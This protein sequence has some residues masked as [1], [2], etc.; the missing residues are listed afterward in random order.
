MPAVGAG[1]ERRDRPPQRRLGQLGGDVWIA[2]NEGKI[3]R[4]SGDGSWSTFHQEASVSFLA[5]GGTGPNDV[6]VDG[7]IF[8]YR[9]DGSVWTRG[10]IGIAQF[11]IAAVEG[12]GAFVGGFSSIYRRESG[13]TWASKINFPQGVSPHVWGMAL[14]PG[15]VF[16]VG[17]NAPTGVGIILQSSDRGDTWFTAAQGTFPT[18]LAVWG[19]SVDDLYACGYSGT[20]LRRK[21]AGWQSETSG[22]TLKLTSGTRVSAGVYVVGEQGTVLFSTGDGRWTPERSGTTVDLRGVWGSGAE[23]WAVG[24]DG[25]I[26]RKVK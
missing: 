5:V 12:I 6:L 3:L 25:V 11:S 13:D 17:L 9:W 20:L 14:F 22:T 2:A 1:V 4:S 23:V 16:A 19:P 18:L 15:V 8:V 10:T 26:L 21:T 24:A 7:G